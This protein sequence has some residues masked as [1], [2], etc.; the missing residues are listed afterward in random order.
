M[1]DTGKTF[2]NRSAACSPSPSGTNLRGRHILARDRIRVVGV[3]GEGA[4]DAEVS[5]FYRCH[6][7]RAEEIVMMLVFQMWAGRWYLR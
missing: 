7:C 2:C 1:N 5:R 6:G 3:L 4:V